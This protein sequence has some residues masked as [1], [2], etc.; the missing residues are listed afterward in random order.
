LTSSEFVAQFASR[1]V[2]F[3]V[4]SE[5]VGTA[6]F[7]DEIEQAVWAVNGSLPLGSV[8]TLGELYD[9][10]MARTSLTLVLLAI[11]GGMALLLGLVGIYGVISYLVAQ[12]TREIG[13]RVALGAQHATLKRMV[14]GHV[15]VLVLVG[16]AFGLGGAA[17][18]SRLM[19]SLLFGVTALDPATYVLVALGL[20]VT[21]A[22]AGYLPARRVTRVDPM[23]A[24]RA[25]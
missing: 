8:Q 11:T 10:S 16:V 23:S 12:R 14:L 5:R 25:E 21:A 19:K 15:V 7:L 13:I 1:A 4:R 17:A 2:Y 20:V 18:L 3:F 22:I 6:G 9:R 24:L